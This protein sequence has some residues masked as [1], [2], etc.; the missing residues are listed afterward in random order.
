[1]PKNIIFNLNII[2]NKCKKLTLYNDYMLEIIPV[3]K[4]NYKI[5]NDEFSIYVEST[6]PSLVIDLFKNDFID[7]HE[8]LSCTLNK[9]LTAT[10]IAL[11]RKIISMVRSVEILQ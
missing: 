4:C 1:M 2:D 3:D 6:S 5:F 7:K 11:K 10:M 8:F 9:D